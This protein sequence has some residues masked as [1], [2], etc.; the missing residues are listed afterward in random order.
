MY[1]CRLF[2]IQFIEFL[3][4]I[5]NLIKQYIYCHCS[6][7][8]SNIETLNSHNT[9]NA[10]KW[11]IW[12]LICRETEANLKQPSIIFMKQVLSSMFPPIVFWTKKSHQTRH[13]LRNSR[14]TWTITYFWIRD[15]PHECQGNRCRCPAHARRHPRTSARPG[16]PPWPPS[17]AG[18]TWRR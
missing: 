8:K 3:N 7:K 12:L 4:N 1:L 15:S 13:Y 16:S 18:G 2:H 6:A 5:Q 9:S 14:V 17:G 10:G 11:F